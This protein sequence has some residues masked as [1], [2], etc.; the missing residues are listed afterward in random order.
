MDDDS[1]IFGSDAA[2][3]TPG[4]ILAHPPLQEDSP[5][6]QEGSSVLGDGQTAEGM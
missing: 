1:L 4:S 3:G 5:S 2:G 6:G